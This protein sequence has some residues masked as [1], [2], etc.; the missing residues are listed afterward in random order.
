MS[1]RFLGQALLLIVLPTYTRAEPASDEANIDD[2]HRKKGVALAT[3]AE[4]RSRMAPVL[5]MD[6]ESLPQLEP[7]DLWEGIEVSSSRMQ[8]KK[9]GEII[10]SGW[11]DGCPDGWAFCARTTVYVVHHLDALTNPGSMSSYW[12]WAGCSSEGA[13]SSAGG[14]EKSDPPDKYHRHLL[15]PLRECLVVFPAI[16]K[17]PD[18]IDGERALL[19]RMSCAVE[20]RFAYVAAKEAFIWQSQFSGLKKNERAVLQRAL[21]RSD[22]ALAEKPRGCWEDMPANEK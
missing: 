16:P 12:I 22:V 9:T 14:D 8:L 11:S 4:A 13:E 19:E 1:I 17:G 6:A 7:S 2:E 3:A 21:E 20:G 18:R 5:R 10:D 15:A